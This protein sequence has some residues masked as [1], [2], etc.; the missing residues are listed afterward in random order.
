M[1]AELAGLDVQSGLCQ[2]LAAYQGLDK[3]EVPIDAAAARLLALGNYSTME[4]IER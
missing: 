2:K 4:E 1:R 3:P